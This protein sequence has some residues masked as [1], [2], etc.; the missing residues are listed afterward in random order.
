[1]QAQSHRLVR[2]A[3]FADAAALADLSTQLGYPSSEAQVRARLR[4]LDDSER[5]LL[6]VEDE[7]VL[8]GFIDVHVQ[9]TVEQ[10]PYGEVGGLAIA[11]GHRAS[12][13]G[14]TLLAAAAAWSREHGLAHL[15]VRA[16]L[17]RGAAAHG[18]Y[19]HVGCRPVKDQRVYE[20]PL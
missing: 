4:L 20:F 16:N 2:V 12:G 1:M 8:A 14:R 10:E 15:W 9:R 13:L 6:V 19:E 5:T 11:A 3:Q 17:A 18:F 7:G